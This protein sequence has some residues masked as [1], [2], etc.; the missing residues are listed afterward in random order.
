MRIMIIE[1]YFI[2][3]Y[4]WLDFEQLR[5]VILWDNVFNIFIYG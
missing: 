2:V 4:L 3:D 5:E 1:D